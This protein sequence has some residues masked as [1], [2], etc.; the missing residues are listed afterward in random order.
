MKHWLQNLAA[1]AKRRGRTLASLCP[2]ARH[3]SVVVPLSRLIVS[4]R[5]TKRLRREIRLYPTQSDSRTPTSIHFAIPLHSLSRPFIL[6][7]LK[8]FGGRA[9]LLT[10]DC[11]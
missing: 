8:V 1:C 11:A 7:S 9:K 5:T 10:A 6:L 3:H 4:L 2:A